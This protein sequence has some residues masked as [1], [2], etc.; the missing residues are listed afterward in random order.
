LQQPQ[1]SAVVTLCSLAVFVSLF[2]FHL[3]HAC[4]SSTIHMACQ[5]IITVM[6]SWAKLGQVGPSWAAFLSVEVDL[7]NH[8][9]AANGQLVLGKAP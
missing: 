8:A 6:P 1:S 3:W 9:S 4:Q 2:N 5:S 7:L